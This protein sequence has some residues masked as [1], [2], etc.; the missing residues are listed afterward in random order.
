MEKYYLDTWMASWMFP[1]W[2]KYEMYG[3]D[4]DLHRYAFTEEPNLKNHILWINNMH[5]CTA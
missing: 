2:N 5:I 4:F 3:S 1:L